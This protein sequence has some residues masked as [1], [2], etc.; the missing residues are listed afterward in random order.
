MRS[1]QLILWCTLL[2]LVCISFCKSSNMLCISIFRLLN[3]CSN[4]WIPVIICENIWSW[5]ELV[6]ESR[7]LNIVVELWWL[8]IIF[9]INDIRDTTPCIF[10]WTHMSQI[11][12][13][14]C[15]KLE[16]WHMLL[17]CSEKMGHY[18]W[19][20]DQWLYPAWSI[21]FEIMHLWH[22]PWGLFF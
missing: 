13:S 9:L 16:V 18:L 1:T 10:I 19:V 2:N 12:L 11:S 8:F 5:W 6:L 15:W 4:S 14:Q 7:F 20:W 22:R 3:P 17:T 21:G